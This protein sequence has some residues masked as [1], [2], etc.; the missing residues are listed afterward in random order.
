M[1][2]EKEGFFFFAHVIEISSKESITKGLIKTLAEKKK[3][4]LSGD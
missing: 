2:E 3:I 1:R 4:R